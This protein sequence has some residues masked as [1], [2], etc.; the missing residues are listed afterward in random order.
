M[1][2][3]REDFE[4]IDARF[5]A[6]GGLEDGLAAVFKAGKLETEGVADDGDAARVGVVEGDELDQAS[7]GREYFQL[8]MSPDLRSTLSVLEREN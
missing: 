1:S 4:I 8:V 3:L 5:A 2:D 7:G 6:K